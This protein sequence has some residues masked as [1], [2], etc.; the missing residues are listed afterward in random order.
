[1][2]F[3]VI[4][5]GGPDV[6]EFDDKMILL[7]SIQGLVISKSLGLQCAE[8][9]TKNGERK[10]YR[11]YSSDGTDRNNAENIPWEPAGGQKAL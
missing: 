5:R 4:Y 7:L 6:L 9:N 8:I 11:G 2:T 10:F 1:M 3:G